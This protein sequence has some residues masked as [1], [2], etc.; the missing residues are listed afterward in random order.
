MRCQP[1]SLALGAVGKY[2]TT[3]G[4]AAFLVAITVDG[5]GF[6]YFARCWM[7]ASGMEITTKRFL[8]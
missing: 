8:W 5:H 2:V 6:P 7:A 4:G 3:L 1:T